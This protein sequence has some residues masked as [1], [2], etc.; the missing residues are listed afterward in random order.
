M[1]TEEAT[2]PTTPCPACGYSRMGIAHDARCPECGAVGLSDALVLEGVVPRP[3]GTRGSFVLLLVAVLGVPVIVSVSAILR[4]DMA[5]LEDMLALV[6]LFALCGLGF[7]LI[8]PL[9]IEMDSAASRSGH[10]IVHPG[11]VIVVAR[12]KTR[13]IAKA[14][15]ARL[16]SSDS[17]MGPVTQLVLRPRVFSLHR[18][19]GEHV[20]FLR[21]ADEERHLLAQRAE[22]LLGFR[23]RGEGA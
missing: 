18:I 19:T 20:L 1:T 21:G 16:S 2:V 6:A 23:S 7:W 12:G 11:G 8:L 14:S 10:W 13:Q 3:F 15:I 17:L 5:T 9:R 4:Q 22:A